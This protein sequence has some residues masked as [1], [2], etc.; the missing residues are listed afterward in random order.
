M[1][2]LIRSLQIF[3]Q[4]FYR[5]SDAVI[6]A[7]GIGYNSITV[8]ASYDIN[9]SDLTAASNYKGGFEFSLTYVWKKKK[10]ICCLNYLFHHLIKFFECLKIF[11][12]NLNQFLGLKIIRT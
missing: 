7:F 3:S 12:S 5:W 8:V 1:P 6:P 2:I 10:Q 4:I 9:N 11:F